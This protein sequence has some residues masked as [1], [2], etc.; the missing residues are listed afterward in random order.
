MRPRAV[1]AIAW[2]WLAMG[3][4]LAVGGIS[5]TFDQP[6]QP[7]E[8]Y[9]LDL[10]FTHPVLFSAVVEI[11]ATVLILAALAL[12]RLKHWGARV[13][14]VVAWLGL[15]YIVGFGLFAAYL[16]TVLLFAGIT[17]HQPWF[18]AAF[19]AVGV[20]NLALLGAPLVLTIRCL[21]RPQIRAVFV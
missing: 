7:K 19:A 5:S 14:E 12:L 11:V 3:A 16:L 17:H 18:P 13:I 8:F 15:V 6:T 9:I 21:R 2:G 20:L 4:L 10:P 1:S